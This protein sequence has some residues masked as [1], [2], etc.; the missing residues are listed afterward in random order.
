MK[1]PLKTLSGPEKP[2]RKHAQLRKVSDDSHTKTISAELSSII[3]TPPTV[4]EV[5]AGVLAG[6]LLLCFFL[7]I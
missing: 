3:V 4:K 2:I 6:L 5:S 7:I 1:E